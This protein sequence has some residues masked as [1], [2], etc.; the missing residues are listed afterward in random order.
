MICYKKLYDTLSLGLL[1]DFDLPVDEWSDKFMVIPKSSGSN[2]YGNYRTSRTPHAREIM[3]CLSAD[4]PCKEVAVM[5]ASQ[6]FKTQIGL[7]WLS[8]TIHQSPS[9]FIWLMP[10]GGLQK[11][12]SGRIDKTIKA[13]PVLRDLVAKP[14]SRDAK[15]NQDTK[16][17]MGGTLFIFTAGSAANISEVP[18]RYV[19]ID[20]IDRCQRDVDQ[21]GDPKKLTDGRQTTFQQNKKS[22]YPSSPTIDGESR[23]NDLFLSGTQRRA[24][25]ECIHCGHA[26]E[27][28]FERLVVNESGSALYPCESCGGMH[29]DKDKNLMFANGLWTDPVVGSTGYLQ[30]FTAS[31]M[32]LP[33]GWLSWSDMVKEHAA[34]QEKL[35]QGN[36]AMMIVFYNTRLARV[37]KR[38]IQTVSY[39]T[40]IDRAEHYDLRFAPSN[41]LF[42]TA[43]VD[44]QDNRLEVQIVGWGRNMSATIL[45]YVVLHGDPAD[46]DVWDQLTDLIN[47]GIEHESGRVLQ[48]IATAIDVGGHRGEAVKHYVRSKRIRSPIAIIGA[49]KLNAP[50]L[51]KGS[52]QDVTWKGVSDKKGVM[53]H[54][55]GT[56]DIKHVIFSR[57]SNDE[58]KKPGDRMLRFA[59][60]LSPEYFGGL[61]SETYDRQ[62]KRYV[63]KHDGIRNEPL[64][65]LTYAYATLHHSGIRAHRYTKKDW[66]ALEAKFLNPVKVIEKQV[67]SDQQ[68]V[69]ESS[70]KVAAIPKPK[71][72]SRGRSMM[73]SLRDRLRR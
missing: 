53:L 47:S 10:T 72:Q 48:V 51:S 20:E 46:D 34:A 18:A 57:L 56:V 52:M 4:H 23:I 44:T 27:L 13:V 63:K 69:K 64:D 35:D 32:Y 40:L 33:Y 11:R 1:P 24:L 9:N 55:V 45:D 70:Q 37:W 62:K 25:A 8:S 30:S 21:E 19:I 28:I 31:A 39:Q 29:T 68:E 6:M 66:D 22:Y 59:K 65:T 7:N 61:I 26:Q 43:G 54:Q 42:V 41:V 49:T 14:N 3:R 60:D 2:E 17:Y 36:D 15:N 71:L 67:S 12:I 5:V 16:E 50:V 58:D 38:T 73:G